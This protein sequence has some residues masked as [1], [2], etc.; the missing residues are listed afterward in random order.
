MNSGQTLEAPAKTEEADSAL[1]NAAYSP[2]AID[3]SCR[4][5]LL[6]LF[7]CASFWLCQGLLAAALVSLQLIIP[8][9]LENS[10]WL[11]FGHLQPLA[12]A[13]SGY[14]FATQAGVGIA[15]WLIARLGGRPLVSRGLIFAGLVIWN[16][17]VLWGALA[18][19]LGHATGFAWFDFPET[20]VGLLLFG[21]LL[22][23]IAAFQ[24][25]HRRAVR[26]LYPSLWFLIAAL[27]WFPWLFATADLL[28]IRSPLR[29]VMQAVVHGWYISGL[30][31]QWL[32]PLGLAVV[33]YF[34]PKVLERPLYSAP[35]AQFTFWLLAV[36]GAGCGFSSSLPLPRWL[37][38]LSKVCL[39]MLPL[40]LVTM[41]LNIGRTIWNNESRP[42]KTTQT[43]KRSAF[44]FRAP[45]MYLLLFGV[46]AW[47][48]HGLLTWLLAWH[49][50]APVT[51]FTWL[52]TGTDAFFITGFIIVVFMAAQQYVVPQIAGVHW[53]APPM[54]ALSA[55]GTLA[56]AAL[57][58]LGYL[59]AG[60]QQGQVMA[61]M[62]QPFLASVMAALPGLQVATLGWLLLLASQVIFFAQL[63]GLIIRVIRAIRGSFSFT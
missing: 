41:A 21:Y 8:G 40:A 2:E 3:C 16:L 18:I 28:L 30:F 42:G 49:S 20:A 63:L 60:T 62:G 19:H 47:I 36:F 1:T 34:I 9:F 24:T 61:D 45:T 22:M 14:G 12:R 53:P 46:C 17:G 25:F 27:F 52:G 10:A 54:T 44:D 7:T 29:G 38:A 6:C 48:L 37:P 33:F 43:G 39:A 32:T 55:W 50:I 35:L 5:P 56:G 57:L 58:L 31:H 15:L 11:T 4:G 13:V 23:A 51:Q 26:E 59:V